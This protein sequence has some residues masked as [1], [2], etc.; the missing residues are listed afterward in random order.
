MF[1]ASNLYNNFRHEV[2]GK[3]TKGFERALYVVTAGSQIFT[4]P[5]HMCK[6]RLSNQLYLK[7]TQTCNLDSVTT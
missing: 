6:V 7:N 4:P 2:D 3:L 1:T 5:V